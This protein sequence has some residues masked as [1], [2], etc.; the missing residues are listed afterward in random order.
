MKDRAFCHIMKTMDISLPATLPVFHNFATALLIGALLGVER[1]KRKRLGNGASIGG[2]RT[3]IL[4][5]LLGA[6]GGWLSVELALPWLLIAVIVVVAIIVIAG[7]AQSVKHDAEALGMTTELAAMA[8]VML[9]AMVMLGYREM[10]V[11]LAVTVAA[12][13]AYKEPLHGVVDR[14]G[15]DDVFAGLRLLIA[16]FIVLPLLPN[17]SI[18]PWDTLNLYSLWILV[19]LISSLSLAGYIATRLFGSERGILFTGISGGLV[20][21]TAVTLSFARNSRENE[22]QSSLIASSILAAWCVMYGRVLVVVLAVNH[23]I[24]SHLLTALAVMAAV[25]GAMAWMLYRKNTARFSSAGSKAVELKNPFS[26]TAATK[27]ALFFALVMLAVKIVSEE[28]SGAGMYL[29]AALAGMTDVD[30]IT[31]AMARFALKGE[32]GIAVSAIV[33]AILSNTVVKTIMV[34]VLGSAE[35]R[36]S[37]LLST[38]G[39]LLAGFAVL[40]FL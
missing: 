38:V 25:T 17:Q 39:I 24:L 21:S 36:K 10:A 22:A 15:S 16:T 2:L 23:N 33:I 3:F 5:S 28:L 27:F 8:A 29:I 32:T 34:A 19:L 13:L 1:E 18:D 9:G 30:A 6:L 4:F 37:M 12:V 20:S 11:A 14:I 31:L 7:Y 40:W 35:L 26:L